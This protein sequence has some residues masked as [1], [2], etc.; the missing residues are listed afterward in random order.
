[1]MMVR[2]VILFTFSLVALDKIIRRWFMRSSVFDF[3]FVTLFF[4]QR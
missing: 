1:M 4:F 2:E 3:N